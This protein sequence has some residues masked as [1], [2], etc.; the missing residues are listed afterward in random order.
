MPVNNEALGS[1][2]T[3]MSDEYGEVELYETLSLQP[4]LPA[5]SSKPQPSQDAHPIWAIS[6]EEVELLDDELGKGA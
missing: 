3:S 5:E 6:K 1:E 4:E 2:H